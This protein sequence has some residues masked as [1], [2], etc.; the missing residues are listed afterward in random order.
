MTNY[1]IPSFK[2]PFDICVLG[3]VIL[4]FLGRGILSIKELNWTKI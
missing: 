1:K 4:G 3:F 2:Q